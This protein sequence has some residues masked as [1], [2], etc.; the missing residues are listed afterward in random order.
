[1]KSLLH[2]KKLWAFV[3]VVLGALLF[4]SCFK[5][6]PTLTSAVFVIDS[7]LIKKIPFADY[8]GVPFDPD[9]GLDP[10]AYITEYGTFTGRHINFFDTTAML[11]PE[12]ANQSCFLYVNEDGTTQSAILG[13]Y[14]HD[15]DSNA[16]FSSTATRL[17]ITESMIQDRKIANISNAAGNL[18]IKLYLTWKKGNITSYR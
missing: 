18:K 6:K 5:S 16:D 7:I 11:Y 15:I 9:G 14:L 8:E 1:M 3:C 10:Y 2:R 4:N 17:E 12:N 13:F